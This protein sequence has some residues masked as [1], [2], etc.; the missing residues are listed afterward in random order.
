VLSLHNFCPIPENVPRSE[1]SANVFLLSSADKEERGQAIKYSLK[2]MQLAH[3]LEAKAAV[4]HVGHVDIDAKKEK[5][6]ELFD[7]G[8]IDSPVGK[9]FI[10]EQ[11]ALRKKARQKNVD[12]VLF[13]LERLNKEAEKLGVY[14]GVENR[15]HFH[16]MPDIE[17]IGMILKEFRGG[18]IRYWH[19]VGH[20]GVQEKFGVLKQEELLLS[21]SSDLLGMHIHD[22]NGYDDHYAPG[23]GECDYDLIKR[24]LNSNVIKIVEVHSKVS[25]EELV[26]GMKFLK[27]NGIE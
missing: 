25:R 20:A 11:L 19:D 1:A 16:E 3:D 14:V 4:F 21:Y 2:T 9:S 24:H 13:S 17:E 18:R 22:F 27:S 10:E 15:Y 12:S 8:E 7:K 5:F 26:K 23:T 6:F